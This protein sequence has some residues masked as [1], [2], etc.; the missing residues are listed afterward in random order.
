MSSIFT[1]HPL[2]WEGYSDWPQISMFLFYSIL[3][4]GGFAAFAQ[5]RATQSLRLLAHFVN[6]F[7]FPACQ[8]SIDFLGEEYHTTEIH[9]S[10]LLDFQVRRSKKYLLLE[11]RQDKTSSL[12]VIRRFF[13]NVTSPAV[14]SSTET[15]FGDLVVH[16]SVSRQ[17]T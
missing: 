12:E 7:P 13:L 14:H 6:P 11:L 15:Q 3:G 17:P 5:E 8:P 9:L 16:S 2:L 10:Q 1:F 4:R